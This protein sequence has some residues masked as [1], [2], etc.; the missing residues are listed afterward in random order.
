ML[1]F[2]G[3]AFLFFANI[4]GFAIFDIIGLIWFDDYSQFTS[5]IELAAFEFIQF[6]L[7][8][9]L[10]VIFRPRREWPEFY[11]IGLELLNNLLNI[12]NLV[13]NVQNH[14]GRRCDMLPPILTFSINN[15]NL[16]DVEF[17]LKTG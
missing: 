9:W 8:L 2:R 16:F 5:F 6:N 11:G 7:L 17:D 10:M 3:I 13:G 14:N 4:I 15:G 1:R 12:D